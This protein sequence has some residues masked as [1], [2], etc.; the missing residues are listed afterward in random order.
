MFFFIKTA[1]AN[2]LKDQPEYLGITP[3]WR[4]ATLFEGGGSKFY[5]TSK[6]HHS[7]PGTIITFGNGQKGVVK[8]IHDIRGGYLSLE[9]DLAIGE[10]V[11]PVSAKPVKTW[12]CKPP[13]FD[14]L[15]GGITVTGFGRN[16][17]FT[18]TRGALWDDCSPEIFKG[19]HYLNPL[20]GKGFCGAP[21]F[22]QDYLL[23]IN[24]GYFC[25]GDIGGLVTSVYKV[26]GEYPYF[27]PKF[28]QPP[29]EPTISIRAVNGQI[30]VVLKSPINYK[31]R[32]RNNE[33]VSFKGA[34]KITENENHFKGYEPCPG[35]WETI[36]KWNPK[37]NKNMFFRAEIVP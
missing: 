10:L 16:G 27:F 22:Y 31:Y 24:W 3:D 29:I 17:W 23:G 11:N 15:D 35:P 14:T 18:G 1:V 33:D 6:F 13:E 7:E 8:M 2:L 20:I 34:W 25:S 37:G 32:I 12:W 4:Y 21:I 19:L 28:L 36:L 5:F 26:Q 30:E 9:Y